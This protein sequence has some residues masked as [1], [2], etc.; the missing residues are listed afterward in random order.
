VS[1]TRT[2]ARSELVKL[3]MEVVKQLGSAEGHSPFA[4]GLG[5]SPNLK[6]PPRLGDLGG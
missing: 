6:S 5:V 1:L 3:W 4:G 2:T